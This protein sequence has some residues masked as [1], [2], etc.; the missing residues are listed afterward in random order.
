MRIRSFNSRFS[1]SI[2]LT[3]SCTSSSVPT[4]SMFYTIS[5]RPEW[6]TEQISTQTYD[7]DTL[8]LERRNNFDAFFHLASVHLC[9]R[10]CLSLTYNVLSLLLLCLFLRTSG[11]LGL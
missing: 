1:L 7:V 10:S 8:V 9:F 11:L 3:W 5:H 6:P 4:S 2:C